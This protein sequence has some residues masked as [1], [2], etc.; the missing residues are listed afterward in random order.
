MKNVPREKAAN[1]H[2][3]W[4]L[5]AMKRLFALFIFAFP[6]FAQPIPASDHYKATSSTTVLTIQQPATN[7][8][9]ITFGDTRL[10]IAGATVYCA[11]AST[12]TLSWNQVAATATAGT[13]LKLLGTF[14]PSG[15]TVWTASNVSSGT[16][17][18]ANQIPA[19]G[20]LLL[21]LAWF[22]LGTQGTSSN[23][24]ITTNN[25]CTITFNYS[26]Q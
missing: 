22:Q 20:T 18:E 19:G 6:I 16:S 15:A 4:R 14:Q 8:R 25:T 24:T 3:T 23:I 12:A 26:A 17:G 13:E 21:S 9:Q 7:A 2:D 5:N 1:R 11:S 10:G